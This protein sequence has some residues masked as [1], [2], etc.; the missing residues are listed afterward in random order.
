MEIDIRDKEIINQTANFVRTYHSKQS[1][2][3]VV[4]GPDEEGLKL[5]SRVYTIAKKYRQQEKEN[6]YKDEY[7]ASTWRG[8]FEFYRNIHFV[9]TWCDKF[10]VF[11][12]GD[13]EAPAKPKAKKRKSEAAT[14]LQSQELQDV[15]AELVAAGIIVDG[16]WAKDVSDFSCLATELKETFGIVADGKQ[17]GN[18]RYAWKDYAH[19]AGFPADK[20]SLE[21]ARSCSQYNQHGEIDNIIRAICKKVH[22][23][24]C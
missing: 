6:H 9:L 13:I 22:A 17:N 2:L 4:P 15:K 7:G 12:D 10:S 16:R 14:R 5:L 3:P 19:F 1:K 11:I 24:Y 20:K 23:K 18:T 8:D 21:S